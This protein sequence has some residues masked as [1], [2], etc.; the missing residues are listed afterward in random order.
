MRLYA[1]IWGVVS[2]TGA[3]GIVAADGTPILPSGAQVDGGQPAIGTPTPLWVTVETD[4]NG[5]NDMVY[6]VNLCQV[7][8]LN[9][10]EDP[11]FATYGIPFIPAVQQGVAPDWYVSRVQQQFSPYF[12][13]LTIQR[14]TDQ[15]GD[16]V[17][18]V[19]VM[20]HQGVPLNAGVPIPT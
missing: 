8:Q 4:A 5:N 13:S 18:N 1:R 7:L 20:T 16:P 10:G 14:A 6:L 12:A 19:N 9:L 15:N 11:Q 3:T 17:Y 2:S